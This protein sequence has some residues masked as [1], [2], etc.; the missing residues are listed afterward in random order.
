MLWV[1][2]WVFIAMRGLSLVVEHGC[3]ACEILTP[4]QGLEPA[5]P[6][7]E[8]RFLTSEPSGKSL[9][10]WFLNAVSK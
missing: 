5:S 8:G 9:L 10:A 1:F 7:L 2:S 6:A 4:R 3:A